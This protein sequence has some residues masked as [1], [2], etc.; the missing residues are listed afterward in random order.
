MNRSRSD[1]VTK[2]AVDNLRK[3]GVTVAYTQGLAPGFPDTLCAWRGINHLMEWK[4]LGQALREKQVAFVWT[5]NGCVHVATNSAE[6]FKLIKECDT[7][8]RALRR[9]MA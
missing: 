3:M 8:L 4:T 2:D 7:R 1:S 5:W 9:V 6:A